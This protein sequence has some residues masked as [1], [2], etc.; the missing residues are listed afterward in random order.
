MSPAARASGNVALSL[1]GESLTPSQFFDVVHE[2]RPVRLS[3]QAK[4]RM[5]AA[6]G[7]IQRVLTHPDPVYGV[8]TGFGKLA[9]QRISLSDI[10]QLQLNLVRSHAAGVG[11]PL[12]PEET[13]GLL[14][15]RANV[16]A[17]GHSGV[18]PLV[19][20]YL[21]TL[22]NRNILPIIPCRGSVGASGDLA[23]LA[24]LTLVVIGEGE[25]LVNNRRVSG[26][27]AL[28]RAGL[29]PL[30]LQAKEGLSLRRCEQLVDTADVAG[31]LSVEAL[32]GTPVA[33]E[34]RIQKLR[35]YRGQHTVAANLSALMTGSAI[36]TSHVDCPRV[37]DAYSLRCMPQVHGAV[38][39]ALDHVR[40]TLEIEINSVTD[41]PLVFP[42]RNEVVSGGNF[43]GQPLGLVL[44]YLAIAMTEL[45]SISE[46][47]IERLINPEYGDLP[48]FLS[49][50]PGLH[51]GFMLAQ[52]TAAALTS[53]N[54]VLAH[55]ASV[56][57]IPTSGNQEDHVSM[58]MGSAL[59][60]RQIVS[61]VEYILAIELMC[62][63]QGVD[64]HRP[65]QPGT[66]S[67][68]A[69]QHIRRRVSRLTADRVLAID[70][71]RIRRL[72]ADG[73][74][75]GVLSAIRATASTR[76]RTAS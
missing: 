74:L 48:P 61:N 42:D 75:G 7:V 28:A 34:P 36:R 65:L 59:K 8:T 19:V 53:E 2:K 3:A 44:D 23:P 11:D 55:P 29:K 21:L 16:L 58:G 39:D 76:R 27:V 10:A 26:H 46:R 17:R 71:E 69:L 5:N 56:D 51:S 40:A 22:L 70:I 32:K 35:P 62:A 9:D 6:Y 18:R 68:L 63:A 12:T 15:L 60:L 30:R 24:H 25:A 64:F 54:K 45:A 4:R 49:P 33:F 43:H 66:G 47:R 1:T 31:A 20:D 37:Q 73:I 13:R 38:R 72:V 14:L 52:V 57:S 67:R 50:Q 41:N